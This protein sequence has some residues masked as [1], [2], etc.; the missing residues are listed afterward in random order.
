MKRILAVLVVFSL[1]MTL[2]ACGKAQQESSDADAETS[3]PELKDED[4]TIEQQDFSILDEDGTVL[5]RLTYDLAQLPET[6]ESYQKINETLRAACGE[7]QHVID[8]VQ[9]YVESARQ[10]VQTYTGTDEL[11]SSYFN[12]CSVS[13]ST[14]ENGVLSLAFS[15]EWFMGGVYNRNH[16]GM[17]FDLRT[18]DE[19]TLGD[20]SSLDDAVVLEYLKAC[21][22]KYVIE[23][24]DRYWWDNVHE[25]VED[26]TL[27]Q[28]M[29]GQQGPV[30][31]YLQGGEI[32]LCISTY[33]LAPGAGGSMEIPT[34]LYA[35][36][37][38]SE[39]EMDVNEAILCRDGTWWYGMYPTGEWMGIFEPQLL[40]RDD[41][42]CRVTHAYR[43]SDIIDCV[44]GTYEL[45]E[46]DVLTIYYKDRNDADCVYQ[47]QV[48]LIGAG[49]Q[50][51]QLGED[52]FRN[53]YEA[54]TVLSFF[55]R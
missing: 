10:Y 12:T 14:N 9:E 47:Y 38:H 35:E 26:Y 15:T 21:I 33:E 28:L 1:L 19:M 20:L 29:G 16:S 36:Q 3:A 50:L 4:I 24:P 52:A 31:I 22:H 17:T 41:S 8:E 2:C 46:N 51:L 18:G 13:V 25:S 44:D 53:G 23:N 5:I 54:G 37:F 42:T 39:G 45:D 55:R 49:L 32:T 48:T 40:L 7:F 11:G 6:T 34:G 30:R 27:D 43:D